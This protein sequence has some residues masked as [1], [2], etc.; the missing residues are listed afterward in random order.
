MENISTTLEKL[1]HKPRPVLVT[2]NETQT[3]EAQQTREAPAA[4]SPNSKPDNASVASAKTQSTPPAPPQKM[5]IALLVSEQNPQE[6]LERIIA[7]NF[8]DLGRLRDAENTD[9][10]V[11]LA[12][13]WIPNLDDIPNMEVRRDGQSVHLLEYLYVMHLR[14]AGPGCEWPINLL[15]LRRQWRIFQEKREKEERDEQQY[16]P[17]SEEE[18]ARRASESTPLTPE[19]KRV[20]KKIIREARKQL[21]WNTAEYAR[22]VRSA[23]RERRLFRKTGKT[24]SE[25]KNAPETDTQAQS[26]VAKEETPEQT[27]LRLGFSLDG[28]AESAVDYF[29]KF[30]VQWQSERPHIRMELADVEEA[31]AQWH[32]SHSQNA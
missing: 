17:P 25:G 30:H 13:S 10:I 2:Q 16:S 18:L 19:E 6:V 14:E 8:V 31:F 32:R 28:A 1:G 5:P 20:R 15:T 12:A 22:V 7:R 3:H 21:P 27:A 4:H 9:A 23:A 11:D 24:T 26:V 29:R